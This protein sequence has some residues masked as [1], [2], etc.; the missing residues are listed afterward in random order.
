MKIDKAI[1]F[2]EEGRAVFWS[3]FLS[4]RS[5]FEQL[6]DIAPKLEEK[7]R[8]TAYALELGSHRN[9]LAS[10][11]DNT[12]RLVV[13]QEAARLNRLNEEW[14]KTIEDVRKLGGFEDFL[15]PRSLSALQ[16]AASD[17][18]VVMLVGNE[19]GSDILILTST[20]VCNISL[21]GLPTRKLQKLV[22]LVQAASS[23]S[24]IWRSHFEELF[25]T[26]LTEFPVAI[27]ETLRNWSK[28][29]E[30][31][32]VRRAEKANSD[33]LFKFVLKTLWND[34]VKPVIDKLNLKVRPKSVVERGGKS[35]I[36]TN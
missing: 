30:D 22:H 10:I 1:Q 14:L 2:L 9:T 6:H 19:D 20:N 24:K 3:Q 33:D 7:L 23:A 34:V 25:S 8:D 13:D 16:M 26:D 15:R 28:Q 18:P 35:I 27:R 17:G 5:P 21:P 32:G 4:L 31:R 12:Q 36:I 11:S 29:E